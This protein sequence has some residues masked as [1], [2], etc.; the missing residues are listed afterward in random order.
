MDLSA[1]DKAR[2]LAEE[3][4]RMEAR[5]MLSKRQNAVPSYSKRNTWIVWAILLIMF[6]VFAVIV[7]SNPEQPNQAVRSTQA[8]SPAPAASQRAVEAPRPK[9]VVRYDG[10]GTFG[11]GNA[12]DF[13]LIDCTITLNSGTLGGGGYSAS[14]KRIAKR[15]ATLLGSAAFRTSNG[16]YYSPLREDPKSMSLVCNGGNVRIGEVVEGSSHR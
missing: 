3:K 2:I 11:I 4:Y 15:N 1:E 7:A 9:A 10:R 8:P 14:V 5:A 13:D 12:N 16:V 6:A